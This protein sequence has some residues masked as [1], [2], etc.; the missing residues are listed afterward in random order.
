MCAPDR[1]PNT[2]AMTT[3]YQLEHSPYCIPI[4]AILRALDA[5]L[6]EVNVPN[7]DRSEIIRLTNGAYYQVPVLVD[8]ER[9]IFESSPESQDV[10]RYVDDHFAAGRLFAAR[11]EGVQAI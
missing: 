9:V 8:N 10:A 2:A 5:P 11:L 1:Q 6:R 7:A 3:I 4:V